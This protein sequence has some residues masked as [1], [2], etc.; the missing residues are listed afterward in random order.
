MLD[1]FFSPEDGVTNLLR[2]VF[3]FKR[4]HGVISQKTELITTVVRISQATSIFKVIVKSEKGAC[5]RGSLAVKALGYKP[6]GR[7]FETR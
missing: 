6:E 1:L 3:T 2:N 4:L 7:R 5:A